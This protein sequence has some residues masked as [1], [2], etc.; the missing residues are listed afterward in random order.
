MSL[1]K[2]ISD[3]VLNAYKRKKR[4]SA[5]LSLAHCLR[6]ARRIASRTKYAHLITTASGGVPSGSAPSARLVQP[7]VAADDFEFFIGTDPKSRK[8][9]EI[10]AHPAVTLA[11]NQSDEDASLVV[12]GTATVHHEPDFKEEYWKSTWRLFFPEGPQSDNYVVVRV[13]AERMELLSFQ[14]NVIPEPFGLRPVVL[15]RGEEGWH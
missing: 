11:F 15:V 5:D 3:V 9:A 12:Y 7:I 13:R 2:R 1:P 8:V 6:V 4:A 14:R 10:T